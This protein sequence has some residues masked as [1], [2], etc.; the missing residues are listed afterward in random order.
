[1]VR[2]AVSD[3]E[4]FVLKALVLG[5]CALALVT[6]VALGTD[7]QSAEAAPAAKPRKAAAKPTAA[8]RARI[9]QRKLSVKLA[10]ARKHRRTIARYE[11]R[12]LLQAQDHRVA[13]RATLQRARRDLMRTTR[14]IAYYRRLVRLWTERE[15]AQRLHAA[16]PRAAICGVFGR[17]C[18]QAVAI[19]WCESR[20]SPTAANG[21]YLGLFQMGSH[22][23]RLFGHGPTP[24]EQARAA[25]RYF[26]YSGRDW[27]P[28]GCRWAAY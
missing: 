17:Y 23:R 4:V 3:Q 6:Q 8:H 28:W 18:E 21:Q 24:Y 10:A 16:A 13:A 27:S 9:A 11:S 15:R 2:A 14:E 1:V 22:E 5:L 26:V 19:A 25:H 20:L 7:G 12:A